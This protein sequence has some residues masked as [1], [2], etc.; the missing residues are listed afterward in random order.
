MPNEV[1]LVKKSLLWDQTLFILLSDWA[2]PGQ[3]LPLKIRVFS[4]FQAA[5]D[6][7]AKIQVSNR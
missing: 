5:E 4:D 7:V 1:K 3:V 6:W 2:S